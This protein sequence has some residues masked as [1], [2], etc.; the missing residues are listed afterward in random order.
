M[1]CRIPILR[2]SRGVRD[3]AELSRP[4]G[5][6]LGKLDVLIP[7]AL[8]LGLPIEGYGVRRHTYEHDRDSGRVAGRDRDYHADA[9]A[10]RQQPSVAVL[11]RGAA[12][13][14]PRR[15]AR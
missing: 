3:A 14:D 6:F 15:P 1:E 11:L 10:L 8:P 9:Q 12:V 4:Y 5:I 7:K 2:L 13:H